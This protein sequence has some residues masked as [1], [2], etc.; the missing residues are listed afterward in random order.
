MAALVEIPDAEFGRIYGLVDA[1]A[2][3]LIATGRAAALSEL[4]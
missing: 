1:A 4:L 2:A 3:R